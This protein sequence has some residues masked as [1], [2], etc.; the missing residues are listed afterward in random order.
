MDIKVSTAIATILLAAPAPT[1]AEAGPFGSSAAVRFDAKRIGAPVVSGFADPFTKR[2]LTADDPVRVASISK[3]VV[4]LGVMRMVEAGQLDLDRDVSDY[5]GWRFRNPSFPDIP[6]TLRLL[7]SH[8]SSVTDG[9][10]YI[11]A[12]GETV[13]QRMANPKAWDAAHP[14]GRYFRYANLNFP[15][16]ASIMEKAGGERFDRLMTKLVFQPLALD[17]CFNWSGCSA[18]AI[19]RAVVLTDGAGLVRRDR[20]DGKPPSC[21]VYPAP[22]GNCNY[23]SVPLGENGGMFS[24][25]G[26]M[27]ISARDLAKIGQ[28]LARRGK[29]FLSRASIRT[30]TGPVWR[31]DGR[32][33]DSEGGFFCRFGLSVQT[34]ANAGNSCKDDPFG[35]RRARIGH[36][37]EAYGLRSGL[38]L[39]PKTGKGIAF[40][41]T[42]VADDAP[43]GK[44]AFT[45]VE[46]AQMQSASGPPHK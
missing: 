8:R 29:G 7:L 11:L 4:A 31:Y 33:G 3:L 19:S 17:A 30:L 13:Q 46:E 42:A 32:N 40:F 21:L 39:D 36:A 44:S 22:D 34:L 38:W 27:R 18:D 14:P 9:A 1:L 28:L 20:L 16:I 5:L 12:V 45:A 35:D 43:K 37:G 24:P 41:V 10:E 23:E 26:G 25:Q 6:I 2:P 15:L